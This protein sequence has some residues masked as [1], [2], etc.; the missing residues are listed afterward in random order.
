M[1][2]RFLPNSRLIAMRL[3]A[4]DGSR[5]FQSVSTQILLLRKYDL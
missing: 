4:V 5:S 2:R 1:V 3:P